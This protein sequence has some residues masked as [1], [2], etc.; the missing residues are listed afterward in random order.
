MP[1]FGE[2]SKLTGSEKNR[3]TVLLK[4]INN[5][6]AKSTFDYFI[7]KDLGK[8]LNRELDFYIK[9]EIMHLDDIDN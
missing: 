2:L 4:H 7:H 5:F 6:T 9:N 1:I 3:M 8:F